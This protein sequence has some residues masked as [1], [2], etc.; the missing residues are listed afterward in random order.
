MRHIEG[1]GAPGGW[2]QVLDHLEQGR[3]APAQRDEDDTLLVEPIQPFEGG[4]LGIEDEMPRRLAVLARPE[5]DEAEDLL[6]LFAL[7]DVGVRVAKSS[8][9][10]KAAKPSFRRISRTQ[11]LQSACLLP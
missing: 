5:L 8:R 11:W 10:G 9:R 1:H 2:R 6:G 3:R 4:E 7:A